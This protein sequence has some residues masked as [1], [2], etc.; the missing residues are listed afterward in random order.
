MDR[1]IG[2]TVII[3]IVGSVVLGVA[4]QQGLI[5]NQQINVS[6]STGKAVLSN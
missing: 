4:F 3:A 2:F 6:L 5:G 1:T